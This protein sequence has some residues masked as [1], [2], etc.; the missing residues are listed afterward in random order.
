MEL[1]QRWQLKQSA[2]EQL[3]GHWGNMALKSFL[4][5]VLPSAFLWAVFTIIG[6]SFAVGTVLPKARFELGLFDLHGIGLN[7]LAAVGTVCMVLLYLCTLIAAVALQFGFN[8][9]CI[10]LRCGEVTGVGALFEPFRVLPKIVI[11][12]LWLL[13]LG[14]PYIASEL[15]SAFC[16]GIAVEVLSVAVT[17]AYLY[18]VLRLSMSI[19]ILVENPYTSARTALKQ[20]WHIMKG[21]CFRLFVLYLSFFGWFLLAALSLG[22]GMFWLQP[23][24]NM[25][26]VN[27]YYDLKEAC[28]RQQSEQR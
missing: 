13:L 23:Y 19:Y 6:A 10:K 16:S 15:L 7:G 25:T 4:L 28:L 20:S 3:R 11:Y 21:H 24:L 9:A 8:E 18:I 5:T 22:I 2:K 14:L 1:L 26:M 17:I 27:F 12:F